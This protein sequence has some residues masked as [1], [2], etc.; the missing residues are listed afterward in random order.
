MTGFS[1]SPVGF[2][3]TSRARF[4]PPYLVIIQV[5]A[6]QATAKRHVVIVVD[7]QEWNQCWIEEETPGKSV[8][9]LCSA[10][11]SIESKFI[12][13]VRFLSQHITTQ[14][15]RDCLA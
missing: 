6:Q 7:R 8:I 5:K 15:V 2:G 14:Y 3:K 13:C 9:D 10:L 12:K 11:L 1:N 4:P